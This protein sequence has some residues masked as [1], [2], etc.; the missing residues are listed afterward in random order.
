MLSVARNLRLTSW[1]IHGV[2]FVLVVFSSD[3]QSVCSE[4]PLC[5]VT[6]SDRRSLSQKT[7]IFVQFAPSCTGYSLYLYY[8]M[9][10]IV[11]GRTWYTTR[12]VPFFSPECGSSRFPPDVGTCLQIHTALQPRISTSAQVNFV[13][14]PVLEMGRYMPVYSYH[15]GTSFFILEFHTGTYQYMWAG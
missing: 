10:S 11:G 8:Y 9:A 1:I 3:E 5:V 2:K 4:V 15:T 7:A 6:C 12:H 13:L 14:H